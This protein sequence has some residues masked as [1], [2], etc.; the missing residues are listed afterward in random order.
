MEGGE[1]KNTSF[2]I[3]HWRILDS[4]EKDVGGGRHQ[5]RDVCKISE[6]SSLC[7]PRTGGHVCIYIHIHLYISVYISVTFL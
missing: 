5:D 1:H 3:L 2:L 6:K 4:R 7:M